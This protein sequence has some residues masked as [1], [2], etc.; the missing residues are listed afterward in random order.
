MSNNEL[1]LFVVDSILN[2]VKD[3]GVCQV[4]IDIAKLRNEMREDY[5]KLDEKD[6]IALES[7]INNFNETYLQCEQ[8]IVDKLEKKAVASLSPEDISFRSKNLSPKANAFLYRFI[9]A[10]LK[11]KFEHQLHIDHVEPSDAIE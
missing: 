9:L 6:K 3:F 1:D 7:C 8:V 10:I 5:Q 11:A 4:D 2:Y